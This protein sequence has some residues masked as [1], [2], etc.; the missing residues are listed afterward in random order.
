MYEKFYGFREKP[1]QVVPDLDY[2]Y[3]S[4]KHRNALTYLQYGLTENMGI[5]MLTG[6]IG[7]GKTTLTQYMIERLGSGAEIAYIFNPDGSPDHLLGLIMNK[8]ELSPKKGRAAT[9][10]VIN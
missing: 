6:E 10:D 7:S 2:L 9:L 5:I 8:F 1:F 3:L 4:D